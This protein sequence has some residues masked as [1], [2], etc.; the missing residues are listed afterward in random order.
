MSDTQ[1][2][3]Q[4][5]RTSP[6]EIQFQDVMNTIDADYTFT[7]TAFKNGEQENANNENN[8]S[9]KILAFAKLNQLDEASTLHLFGDFYRVDVLQYPDGA[10]HQNIRQFMQHGWQGVSFPTMPLLK[11]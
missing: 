9:C 3:L 10:D 2:L 5:V 4:H 6:E 7:P 1:T 8:G 11:K